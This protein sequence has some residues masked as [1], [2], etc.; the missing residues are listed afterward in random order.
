M[1][2]LKAVLK[3]SALASEI[4]VYGFAMKFGLCINLFCGDKDALDA[5]Q[6][7]EMV[8]ILCTIFFT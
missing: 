7:L 2:I 5:I 1:A 8:G 4:G 6:A 3:A